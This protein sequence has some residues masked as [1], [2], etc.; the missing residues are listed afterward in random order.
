MNLN[1]FQ[2]NLKSLT[3]TAGIYLDVL[4]KASPHIRHE[5]ELGTILHMSCFTT[6]TVDRIVLGG[7]TFLVLLDLT[8]TNLEEAF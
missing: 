7:D 6:S 4:I 5:I 1:I 2:H 8:I 3:N